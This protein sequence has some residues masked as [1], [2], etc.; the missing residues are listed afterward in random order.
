MNM[1]L[2]LWLSAGLISGQNYHKPA[3]SEKSLY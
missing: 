2:R 1:E 3:G